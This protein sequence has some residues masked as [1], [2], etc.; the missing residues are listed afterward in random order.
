MTTLV[1]ICGVSRPEHALVA[2]EA[3]ADLI[4]LVFYPPS[5]R[6]VTPEQAAAI[7][8]A[9]RAAGHATLA[10]GLFVN[11]DPGQVNV[12][13]AAAGLDLV[14]LSGNEQPATLAHLS[15]PLLRSVRIAAGEGVVRVR[16][17]LTAATTM[18]GPREPGPLGQPLTPLLDAHVPGFWGGTGTQ[19][20]WDAAATLARLWPLFLAGGLTPENVGAAIRAVGPLGVDVSSGVETDKVKD[21]AKIRAFIAAARAAD[22]A[23][24]GAA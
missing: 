12:I 10:V 23:I 19:A 20:D 15:R 5:H 9:L 2:A 21:P 4:G 16:E 11:E 22:E 13:A 3:G 24:Q 14:Q 7:V 8:R 17:R 1:K 18:L 6:N